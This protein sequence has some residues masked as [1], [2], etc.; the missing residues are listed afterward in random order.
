MAV[1]GVFVPRWNPVGHGN[2]TFGAQQA[3]VSG[4]ESIQRALSRLQTWDR[5]AVTNS[6]IAG[7]KSAGERTIH[8]SASSDRASLA[9]WPNMDARSSAAGRLA[10]TSFIKAMRGPATTAVQSGAA[11][12]VSISA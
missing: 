6:G 4:R 10:L 2:H 3:Q 11:N 7:S 8:M 1:Q 12:T 9:R 5:Y